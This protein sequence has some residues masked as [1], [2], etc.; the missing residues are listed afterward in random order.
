MPVCRVLQLEMDIMKMKS[1]FESRST[2]QITASHLK[3]HM[4]RPVIQDEFI[5]EVDT[6]CAIKTSNNLNN[7]SGHS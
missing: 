3:P 1:S 7:R 5:K 2:S 6:A 4:D